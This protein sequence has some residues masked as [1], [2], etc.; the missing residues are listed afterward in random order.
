MSNTRWAEFKHCFILSYHR[1]YKCNRKLQENKI[2][3]MPCRGDYLCF[4]ALY[5]TKAVWIWLK[6]GSKDDEPPCKNSD[7]LFS[8][9]Q[10]WNYQLQRRNKHL[11]RYKSPTWSCMWHVLGVE[12]VFRDMKTPAACANHHLL[13]WLQSLS[14]LQMCARVCVIHVH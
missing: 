4:H 5:F 3:F 2:H 10:E 14:C 6:T 9:L 13:G 12:P 8:P 11:R 7:L 1:N